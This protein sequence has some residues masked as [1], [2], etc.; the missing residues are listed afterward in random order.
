MKNYLYH[1]EFF[2]DFYESYFYKQIKAENEKDAII[3]IVSFF[4]IDDVCFA[5]KF[6]VEELNDDW[7]VE[8]F[9]EKADSRFFNGSEGYSLIWIKEIDFDLNMV[10]KLI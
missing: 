2:S 8:T 9:L 3:Q 6:L 4:K 5:E 10:G 7:T 1:F